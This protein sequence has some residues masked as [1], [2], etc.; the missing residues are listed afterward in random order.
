[1]SC[2]G[3]PSTIRMR[4]GGLAADN[5]VDRLFFA[6]FPDPAAAARI[7]AVTHALRAQHGLRGNPLRP[8]RSHVTLHH[9]GDY[10]GLPPSVVAAAMHAASRA[11]AP[12]FN[13]I[14]DGVSSL[15]GRP[16]NRPLVLR[17]D[18]A[19]TARLLALQR[20]L[21][22]AM[23]AA[24]LGRHA[25]RKFVPHVTLLYDDRMLAPQPVERIG[26]TV[27]EFVLVHSLIG[28]GE[29]RILRGWPLRS[30]ERDFH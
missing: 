20:T 28:R 5:P 6:V 14:F 4:L 17:G 19:D 21:G 24:G 12:A 23:T 26:W 7:A 9:L 11:A 16:G 13:V 18:D 1:M 30:T 10:A 15:A 22:E 29:Y 2:H 25:E 3:N 27:R 8:E